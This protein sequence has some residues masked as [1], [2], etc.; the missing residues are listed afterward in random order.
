MVIDKKLRD[1]AFRILKDNVVSYVIGY[2]KGTYGI[3]VKPYFLTLKDN[4]DDLIF[5]PLCGHNLTVYL[6]YITGLKKVGILVK[7]CDS[8][9][10]IQLIQEH[11]I[12]RDNLHIIGVP[13]KGVIDHKKI[14]NKILDQTTIIDVVEESRYFKIL[15]KNH[16]VKR[17]LRDEILQDR[18][19]QCEYPTPFLYDTL[20]AK[21]VKSTGK[22]TYRDVKEFEKKPLE[23]KWSFWKNQF[24]K[25]IRCYACRNICPLCYCSDCVG[26]KLDVTWLRRS[27]NISENTAWNII[28][29]YHLAGRCIGC[30]ECERV[31]PVDIPLHLLNKKIEKDIKELFQYQPG[32]SLDEKPLLG[33]Y[34][35]NEID[36]IVL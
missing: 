11:K 34:K 33:T 32:V 4:I 19:L 36:D 16:R 23:K 25:C 26:E 10:I 5:S 2:K 9:A 21:P 8:R 14:H 29:A 15:L 20:L 27:V 18:C 12:N 28:R 22:E 24:Q 3:Q 1:H 17:I 31:C 35:P 6:K 30:G 7:G 13:C